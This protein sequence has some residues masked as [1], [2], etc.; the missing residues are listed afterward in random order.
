M[1][2]GGLHVGRW[3]SSSFKYV[4]TVVTP[5][6]GVR[7]GKQRR[8]DLLVCVLSFLLTGGL[9][10]GLLG[11]RCYI[12][13][14]KG[15]TESRGKLPRCPRT[16]LVAPTLFLTVSGTP[17]HSFFFCQRPRALPTGPWGHHRCCC[18]TARLLIEV[19]DS[20]MGRS[21]WW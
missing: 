17:H 19:A 14:Q 7:E 11:H 2:L 10:F 18:Y 13:G 16:Y 21:E 20:E 1:V 3:P 6:L 12:A 5:K 8:G 15:E 4:A 9:A